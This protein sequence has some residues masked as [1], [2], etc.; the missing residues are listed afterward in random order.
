MN[1]LLADDN[2]DLR[3]ATRELLEILGHQVVEAARGDEALTLY[4]R[5]PAGVDLLVTD[6]SMPGLD[7]LE[8]AAR[9]VAARPATGVVLISAH[10]HDPRVQRGAA[11]GDVV[12]LRK[13]FS[14]QQLRASVAAAADAAGEVAAGAGEVTADRRGHRT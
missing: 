2:D 14:S 9:V 8:L 5:D 12:L 13:P 10:D 4:E 7:G 1:I 11:N 6:F 3:Q